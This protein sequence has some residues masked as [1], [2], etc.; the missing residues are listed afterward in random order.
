MQCKL[1]SVLVLGSFNVPCTTWIHF[2]QVPLLKQTVAHLEENCFVISISAD[3]KLTNYLTIPCSKYEVT[4]LS[5]FCSSNFPISHS[6]LHSLSIVIHHTH[7][8]IN[9]NRQTKLHY[10]QFILNWALW[11]YHEL[12]KYKP[13]C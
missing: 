2:M 12:S 13:Y 1:H 5:H 9:W 11:W 4:F 7:S 6:S 10:K 8:M 3:L